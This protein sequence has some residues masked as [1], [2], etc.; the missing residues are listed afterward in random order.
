[1]EV[2]DALIPRTHAKLTTVGGNIV[3]AYGAFEKFAPEALP[4][5]SPDWLPL[6]RTGVLENYIWAND[7]C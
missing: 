3:H 2:P 1:M 4:D 7:F 5:V 6:Y